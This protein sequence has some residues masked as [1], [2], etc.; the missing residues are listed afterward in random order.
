M[1]KT[2]YKAPKNAFRKYAS[3]VFFLN[4][5]DA[6]AW[7]EKAESKGIKFPPESDMFKDLLYKEP[8]TQKVNKKEVFITKQRKI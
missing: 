1:V 6:K 4:V 5:A 7:I 2:K 8:Y 3:H